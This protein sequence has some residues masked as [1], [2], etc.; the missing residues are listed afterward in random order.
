MPTSGYSFNAC[1]HPWIMSMK[2]LPPQSSAIA[3]VN[4]VADVSSTADY[5]QLTS[6]LQTLSECRAASGIDHNDE[7]SLLGKYWRQQLSITVY[8]PVDM[9][10]FT[11]GIPSRGPLVFPSTLRA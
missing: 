1:F 7:V 8:A 2:G 3:S 11:I 4:S 6:K 5:R 10:D 9:L